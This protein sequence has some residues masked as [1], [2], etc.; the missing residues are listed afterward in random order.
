MATHNISGNTQRGD[1]A[2]KNDPMVS[3]LRE[4]LHGKN[5]F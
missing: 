2:G 1:D 3:R 4:I 5:V